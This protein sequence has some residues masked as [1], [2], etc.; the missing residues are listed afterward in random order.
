MTQATNLIQKYDPN[1]V[2]SFL[3]G[4]VDVVANRLYYRD[5][6]DLL[7]IAGDNENR[8]LVVPLSAEKAGKPVSGALV[9]AGTFILTASGS[10]TKDA[11]V[12]PAA[13]GKVRAA[14]TGDV[15]IGRAYWGAGDGELV[16]IVTD[17]DVA[18]AS[19]TIAGTHGESMVVSAISEEITL[20]TGG[21]TTDSSANLLPANSEILAVVARVTTTI[22]TATNW[23]LGDA[24]TA[25]RF[26]AATTDLTAGTTKIGMAHRQGGISTDAAGPVQTAA[27]K[28]RV[29][30]TGTP[31]AGKIRVTT[32]YRQFVA[33]TS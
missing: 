19:A 16:S 12:S 10:I 15:V 29:T 28:L 30:T 6:S 3:V 31:G 27:A 22:T 23:A 13:D 8:I 4:A 33:P 26:L 18:S 24:T 20:S 25:A 2:F 5:A 14:T 32:F 17:A 11:L 1:A 9:G 7:V 21:A